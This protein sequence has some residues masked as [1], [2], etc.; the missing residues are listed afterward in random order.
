MPFS[1]FCLKGLWLKS[2]PLLGFGL[3][4]SLKELR[5]FENFKIVSMTPLSFDSLSHGARSYTKL[6]S[7]T[8]RCH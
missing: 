4:V 6:F 7:L 1:S 2:S 8:H 5:A 3:I